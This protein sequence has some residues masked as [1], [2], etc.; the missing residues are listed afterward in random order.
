MVG[1]APVVSARLDADRRADAVHAAP[2]APVHVPDRRA[3]LTRH[4]LTSRPAG[5]VS[6]VPVRRWGRLAASRPRARSAWL[7]DTLRPLRV[8]VTSGG[9][10]APS[11]SAA[12]D[13]PASTR[14]RSLSPVRWTSGTATPRAACSTRWSAGGGRDL[15]AARTAQP[16]ASSAVA[17]S[18]GER[19]PVTVQRREPPSSDGGG[20]QPDGWQ[21]T[22]CAAAASEIKGPRAFERDDVVH[23]G[24]RARRRRA[25]SPGLAAEPVRALPCHGATRCGESAD[26]ARNT[27]H[28]DRSAM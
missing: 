26:S 8:T 20:G 24:P 1:V 2:R 18:E 17:A 4:G 12:T 14:T 9:P 16:P 6:D 28:P 10:R 22:G 3:G 15:P 11:W 7:D 21:R 13:I 27:R 5:S 25:C 19:H 23:T